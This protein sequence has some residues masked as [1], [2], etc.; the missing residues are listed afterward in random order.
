[1]GNKNDEI[2]GFVKKIF[3]KF[4]GLLK[5]RACLS[6]DELSSFIDGKLKR[7]K[8]EE[9]ISHLAVCKDCIDTIRFLRKKPSLEEATVPAWLEERVKDLF[10]SKPKTWEIVL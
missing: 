7:S 3:P 1:M 10:S 5:N 2:K 8:E 6:E 9:L 4:V